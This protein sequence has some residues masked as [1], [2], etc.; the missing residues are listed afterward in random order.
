MPKGQFNVDWRGAVGE[1]MDLST[2]VYGYS[3][4]TLLLTSCI[5]PK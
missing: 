5:A 4:H 1:R 2:G 3:N